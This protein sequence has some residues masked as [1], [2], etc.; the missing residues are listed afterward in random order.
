MKIS[1]FNIQNN[2]KS[3][4]N[5][6]TRDIYN[7]LKDNDID[8]LALQEVF[9]RCSDDLEVLL[10]NKY[11]MVGKYRFLSKFLLRR[12]NEK[13]PII[14]KYK[15]ISFKTYNLPFIPSLLK[16]VITHVVIEY[17]GK[18]ISIY[19][20]HLEVRN[21]NVK[22]RQ[23][24]KIY[25]ILKEDS[26]EKILMGDF[27]LKTNKPLFLDF[28]ESLEEIGMV[29]VPLDEKTLKQSRY[30]REIDHIFI[31]SKFKLKNKQVIKDLDIS[32]HYP[33]IVELEV[34]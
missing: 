34:E 32:D 18:E 13:N 33:V 1:T 8:I 24:N 29:R 26:R 11:H 16:R 15:I 14:T 30:S 27:N 7:Y 9:G 6:K 28:I 22:K 12:F 23:L 2:Y 5:C 31:S 19:N 4:D 21:L 3:Y 10:K 25:S 17:K 20:T